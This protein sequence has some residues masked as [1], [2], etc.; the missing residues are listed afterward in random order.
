MNVKLFYRSNKIPKTNN[1]TVTVPTEYY[2]DS[3]RKGVVFL[4]TVTY[5][6]SIIY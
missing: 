4:L 6:E 5:E 3:S 2:T 1:R